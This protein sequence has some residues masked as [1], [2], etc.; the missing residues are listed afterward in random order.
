MSG[1][2]TAH[3]HIYEQGV[4][5]E[6]CMVVLLSTGETTSDMFVGLYSSWTIDYSYSQALR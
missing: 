6:L 3:V 4:V 2:Y 1:H 5:S